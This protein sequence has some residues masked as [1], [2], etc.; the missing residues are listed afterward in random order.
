[1]F[2]LNLSYWV[3]KHLVN[4]VICWFAVLYS[5]Y[6]QR[7]QSRLILLVK[8]HVYVHMHRKRF[9]K[10]LIFKCYHLLCCTTYFYFTQCKVS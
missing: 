5:L 4:K 1:M 10:D 6:N 2:V 9:I 7:D 3:V 8:M